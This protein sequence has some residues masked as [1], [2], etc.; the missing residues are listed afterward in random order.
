MK[1]INMREGLSKTNLFF[2]SR[3]SRKSYAL[4]S[5]LSKE[6]KIC[7]LSV[8]IASI[9]IPENMNAQT[10]TTRIE[11]EETL[12]E[13]IVTAQRSPVVYSKI[14]RVVNVIDK[15]EIAA[16]PV[17][18]INELLRYASGVDIR[19]RGSDDVQADVV[20]RGG[21]FDQTLVL[22]NGINITD[23]QTGHHNLDL[24]VDLSSIERIEI[25]EGPGSR[26]FGPNAFSGAINI[27]T[28]SSSKD[29]L[30][31]SGVTGQHDYYKASLSASVSSDKY[32][33]F[34]SGSYK[35]STG[36]A[37]NTDFKLGNLFYQGIYKIGKSSVEGQFGYTEK[38]FGA[39]SFYTP[40][41]PDQY[42]ATK[43]IFSSL[44]Y[45]QNLSGVKLNSAVYWRR[46]YDR[47][48]LFRE[49]PSSWYKNH[50]YHWTDV[51]GAN[52]NSS[53]FWSFGR[54]SLGV[55]Y[56]S[57][58]IRSNVLGVITADSIAVPGQIGLYYD[59]KYKREN[60]SIYL[61]HY[62]ISEK[63]NVSA[64]LMANFNSDL[65]GINLYP[66][67]DAA[68]MVGR[69]WSIFSSLNRSLRLPTFTDLFY[70]GP[71]NIGNPNL[72]PE[73]A[74]TLEA[75]LKYNNRSLDASASV[76][77]RWGTNTIDWVKENKNDDWM[78]DNFT[79][80][81]TFGVQL[82]ASYN[83]IPQFGRDF[84]LRQVKLSYSFLNANKDSNG[85]M[86]RYVLD[87][88]KHRFTFYSDF[89]IWKGLGLSLN[90]NYQDRNGSYLKYDF[91]KKS[92][93]GEVP[94]DPFFLMD[95]KAYYNYKVYTFF[96]SASNILDVDYIDISNVT[97]AGRWIKAGFNIK[98]HLEK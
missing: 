21:T 23:P 17:Q 6:V 9:A 16:L 32:K 82:Q 41:Y 27:I 55:D 85:L 62:Y 90:L 64:G 18:S 8:A 88:L 79:D 78:P 36:Y 80:V 65:K 96:V 75:G 60:A 77:N 61:E 69:N 81:N 43:T 70:D 50:N 24:P 33:S 52:V 42:E 73:E 59:H 94:F 49:N 47:F 53:Y 95:A 91:D 84:F 5:V 54:T 83:F 34:F 63:L 13:V 72:K 51:Y 98:L 39:N 30:S 11:R 44:R 97:Q 20:I 25:L 58:H 76:F 45:K 86:S 31:L 10:D 68:Y 19:Q 46:H 89:H 12:D 4:F 28:G 48:E 74:V 29:Y 87:Y 15:D 22:L 56:R 35:S 66:G 14:A 57:E 38:G 26:I 40:V 92:Y 1:T 93:V 37:K 71:N 2:F 67:I 3:W 7:S